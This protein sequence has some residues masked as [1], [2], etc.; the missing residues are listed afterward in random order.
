VDSETQND[1]PLPF[2]TVS[3]DWSV[4]TLGLDQDHVKVPF[5]GSAAAC[6]FTRRRIVFT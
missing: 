5:P 4:T 2:A 1:V 3:E 6:A